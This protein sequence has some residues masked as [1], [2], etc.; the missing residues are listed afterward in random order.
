[1]IQQRLPKQQHL[2]TA[3][4][5]CQMHPLPSCKCANQKP[6][7]QAPWKSQRFAIARL[8]LGS[9]GHW[10][11][12][13]LSSS[14]ATAPTPPIGVLDPRPDITIILAFFC[15]LAI[16]MMLALLF[17]LIL[18]NQTWTIT[19][20][21]VQLVHQEL[22]SLTRKW[23]RANVQQIPQSRST[24]FP[25]T[26]H[27]WIQRILPARCLVLPVPC[28]MDNCRA[29]DESVTRKWSTRAP[30]KSTKHLRRKIP[31]HKVE[32]SAHVCNLKASSKVH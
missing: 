20:S 29:L 28:L 16:A 8:L 7:T 11:A 15:L 31:S 18:S 6:A 4:Q 22:D 13:R 24:I 9:N 3:A 32:T 2:C 1:M 23:L 10:W 25:S 21:H 12:E 14:K 30:V 27:C 26:T 5:I 19:M 17:E